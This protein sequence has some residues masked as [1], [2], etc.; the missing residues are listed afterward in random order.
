MPHQRARHACAAEFVCA[1]IA[2]R[3]RQIVPMLIHLLVERVVKPPARPPEEPDTELPCRLRQRVKTSA[4]DPEILENVDGEIWRSPLAHTD[5]PQLRTPHDANMERR[6]FAFERDGSNQPGTARAEDEYVFNH[7]QRENIAALMFASTSSRKTFGARCRYR[8]F[9]R[10]CSR[11]IVHSRCI[12]PSE[13]EGPRPPADNLKM[14]R[15]IPSLLLSRVK[16]TRQRDKAF[17]DGCFVPLILA[18]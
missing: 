11:R 16:P 5:H 14:R 6:E 9:R 2:V 10:H 15:R 7:E 13:P 8:E 18:N 4:A 12:Q 17:S 3:H 1:E